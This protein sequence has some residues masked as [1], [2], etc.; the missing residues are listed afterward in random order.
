[1]PTSRRRNNGVERRPRER[2]L[3][4]RFREEYDKDPLRFEALPGIAGSWTPPRLV[5]LYDMLNREPRA[6]QNEIAAVLRVE[7][8]GIS[9]KG[10]SID[11]QEFEQTLNMLVGMSPTEGESFAADALRTKERVRAETLVRKRTLKHEAWVREMHDDIMDRV[12]AL[13]PRLFPAI[14]ARSNGASKGSMEHAVLLLSDLHVGQKFTLPETGGINEYN[15][16]LFC[17]RAENLLVGV[18]DIHDIHGDR[19]EELH[20]I[21]LGDMVQGSN[22]GGEWGPAHQEGIS[23]NAQLTIAA[24]AISNMLGEWSRI[25]PRV[26]FV[27]IVGN[28][29]R[30]GVSKNS[31]RVDN[32]FDNFCYT[33][34]KARMAALPNVDVQTA[35]TWWHGQEINGRK[36]LSVH[37]DHI[38]GGPDS[39]VREADKL[40]SLTRMDFDF[41]CMGHFHRPFLT[42]VNNSYAIVN[43]SFV[44]GDVHSMHKLRVSSLPSQ[45]MLGVS[46]HGMAWF[47]NLELDRLRHGVRPLESTRAVAKEF[48]CHV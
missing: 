3:V 15:T 48:G 30:A 19:I 8:S 12:Q 16:G 38:S 42:Q 25:F 13:P 14:R 9:R 34:I 29:G 44:G 27:G 10:N 20:V 5:T 28:H 21:A 18:K 31:D 33:I 22:L 4:A 45:S 17:Q 2:S 26:S 7:R 39:I 24:E 1:M 47:Y 32:N 36:F 43:G 40:R 46:P 37:G 35:S 41:L 11:W 6:T 23:A